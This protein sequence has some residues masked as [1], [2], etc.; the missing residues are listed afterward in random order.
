M[1]LFCRHDMQFVGRAKWT[2]MSNL[3]RCSKC[4]KYFEHFKLSDSWCRLKY[5]D[6]TEWIFKEE[7]MNEK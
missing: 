2:C 5:I 7:R 6:V 4:G 1:G 3:F